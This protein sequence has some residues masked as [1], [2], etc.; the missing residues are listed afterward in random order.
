MNPINVGGL[1][2]LL[3]CNEVSLLILLARAPLV[4]A[5]AFQNKEWPDLI[6]GSSTRL[7]YLAH[8]IHYVPII[9]D[10]EFSSATFILSLVEKST[11][12]DFKVLINVDFWV[13]TLRIKF[14]LLLSF[15]YGLLI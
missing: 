9:T 1:S 6:S 15:I 11:I 10:F 12:L 7:R 13:F 4:T 5:K 8:D 14:G 3:I 2:A